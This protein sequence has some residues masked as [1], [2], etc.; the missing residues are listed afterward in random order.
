DSEGLLLTCEL[1][2]DTEELAAQ[3]I[4]GG[5]G[6]EGRLPVALGENYPAGR[7]LQTDGGLRLQYAFPENAGLSSAFLDHRI[8]SIVRSGL[9]AGAFPGCEVMAARNGKV[10]FQ[11][12]YGYHTYDHR[13]EVRKEDLYDL[14]SV[15]K[16]S[17]PLAGLMVLEGMG[18]FSYTDRLGDYTSEMKHSDKADLPL[19]DILAHQAGLYPWIPYWQDAVKNNGEY[20]RR[21][22][23]VT[24][25]VKYSLGVADHLYL[26]NNYRKKIYRSIRKSELGDQTYVYSGLSFF[27]FPEII[28]DLSG[29]PYEDFLKEK[30]YTRLGAYD[31]TFNPL[32]Y[33][34]MS[35]IVPTEYDSL[36]RKQQI[37]GYVHDEGAAM[38]GGYSGNAGLFSTAND[39]MK[40]FDMYRR[41]GTYGGEE[42]IP[43]D[44]LQE[45]TS[46]QFP[47]TGNRRGLG[48]DKP[49]VDGRDGTP[50]DYPC[51]GASP[52]SFGHSGFT[53]TFVWA[54]PAYGI[55]Y[56]FLSN[57]VYPTR[58]NNLLSEMDIRTNIL[59]ALYDAIQ[60]VEPE[61]SAF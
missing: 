11:R 48:F 21:Y 31:L 42:I 53:G 46:Y 5:I 43:A 25:S 12:S 56:V 4:F 13:V 30:V 9:V 35:R 18:R 15:T 23:S 19:K 39:L 60:Q 52:A 20:K 17:G 49:L 24:P 41:M 10:I 2:D 7:G 59:Q 22:F 16:V 26:N 51:P 29:E 54:D 34:P 1:N 55:T 61:P 38:M 57:R 50:G 33:Y 27:I 6:G 14:A 3:L 40:L 36:F 37:Q 45:Y 32:R 44:V 28:E 47:E 58:N 8:D